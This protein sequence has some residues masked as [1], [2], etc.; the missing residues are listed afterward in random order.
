MRRLHDSI[1]GNSDVMGIRTLLRRRLYSPLTGADLLMHAHQGAW[2][3]LR[4]HDHVPDVSIRASR[5]TQGRQGEEYV[6]ANPGSFLSTHHSP[7]ALITDAEKKLA[8]LLSFDERFK[9]WKPLKSVQHTA[10][11]EEE[12]A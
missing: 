3:F 7:T 8:T 5:D 9:K 12:V 1:S 10:A 11:R 4:G 6:H 2:A